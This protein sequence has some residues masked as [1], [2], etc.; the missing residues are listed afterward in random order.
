MK[1]LALGL[2]AMRTF[3]AG[4][5]E[6]SETLF[7]AEK[8]KEKPAWNPKTQKR[9][10]DCT[11]DYQAVLRGKKPV[12]AQPDPAKESTT[13]DQYYRGDGYQ[14]HVTRTSVEFDGVSGY[15]YG[16]IIEFEPDLVAG[17]MHSILHTAL[18]T[19]DEMKKPAPSG[20]PFHLGAAKDRP[21]WNAKAQKRLDACMADFQAVLD[22]KKPVHAKPAA[23]ADNHFYKGDGYQMDVVE[24]PVTVDGVAGFLYGPVLDL[25]PEISHEGGMDSISHV[26]FYTAGEMKK[27]LGEK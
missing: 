11:V 5:A 26:T 16:P 15:V 10:E 21:D 13:A 4:A 23:P 22:G 17:D 20:P 8:G 25:Q 27:L 18:Y 3:A 12:L 1:L 14:I 24:A 7:H 6:A 9:I 2:L 19:F